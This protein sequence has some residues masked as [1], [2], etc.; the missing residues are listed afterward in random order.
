M[1]PYVWFEQVEVLFD[2]AFDGFQCYGGQNCGF[3]Q[4]INVAVRLY[5]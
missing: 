5:P 2:E 4:D 3:E 1:M